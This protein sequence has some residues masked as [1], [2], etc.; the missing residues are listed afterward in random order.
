MMLLDWRSITSTTVPFIFENVTLVSKV[1]D[2]WEISKS[3]S[4]WH[5]DYPE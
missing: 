5:P 3:K 4:F 1:G 2:I